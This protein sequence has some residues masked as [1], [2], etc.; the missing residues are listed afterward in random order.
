MYGTEW[1][2]ACRAQM[3]AFGDAADYLDYVACDDDARA[4]E[5]EDIHSF[6]TWV[7]G[8]GSRLTGM[9]SFERLA[10][11]TGCA[12]PPAREGPRAPR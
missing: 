1:C 6:P 4:C 7:F 10:G 2:P 9:V 12:P 5:D 8:D 3:E 11:K